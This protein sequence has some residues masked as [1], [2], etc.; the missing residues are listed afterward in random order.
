MN[1]R[2]KVW[3]LSAAVIG[4]LL[5]VGGL[6][7]HM[8]PPRVVATQSSAAFSFGAAGDWGFDSSSK[9]NMVAAGQAGLAFMDVLGDFGYSEA[10]ATTWCSY[11]KSQI[12]DLELIAGNHDTG[13]SGGTS[14][15]AAYVAA[16]PFTLGSLTGNY[17]REYYFDYPSGTPVARFI[18]TGCGV[19]F[20]SDGLGTFNCVV[21]NAH[22]DFV[23][24]AVDGA[25]NAKIPWVIVSLHKPCINAAEKS[26]EVG[27]DFEDLMNAE[28]VD[29]VLT[30]HSHT[31]ERSKQLSC[32]VRTI[33]IPSCIV[34][35]G[36][37]YTKGAGTV[38]T[39]VGTGG[40]DLRG[41]NTGDSEAGYFATLAGTGTPGFGPGFLKVTLNATSMS[42]KFVSTATYTDSFTIG[43]A[44][45][46]PP[47]PPPPPANL[48]ADFSF[49]PSSAVTNQTVTFTAAVSGGKPPYSDTWTFGDGGTG[50]GSTATHV[51]ALAGTYTVTLSVSDSGT[52]STSKSKTVMVSKVGLI[53]T[54]INF[55]AISN[56]PSAAGQNITI[57]FYVM[58]LSNLT[59][60]NTGAVLWLQVRVHGTTNWT[61]VEGVLT[62]INGDAY[63]H[64]AFPT[65]GTW[66]YEAVFDGNA[67]LAPSVSAVRTHTV[68]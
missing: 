54:K 46:P 40:F 2:R 63:F 61:R 44:A 11:F 31:Y 59:R 36:P 39:T 47:P 53:V 12:N 13:E 67:T 32:A 56:E 65:S 50:S 33:F 62:N 52:N 35:A 4:V 6:V 5:I 64:Y 9:P 55:A 34:N 22:Y 27:Q 30:G 41:V 24:N 49:S 1:D 18:E 23:R 10:N 17:G 58:Y 20:V 43:G 8:D 28:K 21:G 19:N 57:R 7:L 16:C 42:A 3:V 26:C 68:T 66:D 37:N 45:A 14:N 60:I 38:W 48:T 15:L 51:Y 25:H 29:L